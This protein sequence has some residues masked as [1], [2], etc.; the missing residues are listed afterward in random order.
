MPFYIEIPSTDIIEA[1]PK[2]IYKEEM[3][4][5]QGVIDCFIEEEDGIVLI[6]Y[7]TDYVTDENKLEV[8]KRYETQIHYYTLALEAIMGKK[9]KEKYLYLFF[10]EEAIKM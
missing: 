8:I 1:L 9:V 3:I 7:K 2:E 10:S 5:V 6:D 4:R